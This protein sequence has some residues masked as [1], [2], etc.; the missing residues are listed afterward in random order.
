MT[1]L[2]T[3]SSKHQRGA[4]ES[5]ATATYLPDDFMGTDH[6]VVTNGMSVACANDATGWFPLDPQA[7]IEIYHWDG[8]TRK[9]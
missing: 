9:A 2:T 5:G 7:N 8:Q 4:L 1:K 3:I 6:Q